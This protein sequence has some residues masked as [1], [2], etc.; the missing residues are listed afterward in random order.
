MPSAEAPHMGR[1]EAQGRRGKWRSKRDMCSGVPA[2]RRRGLILERD[3]RAIP[4]LKRTLRDATHCQPWEQLRPRRQA[5]FATPVKGTLTAATP[6]LAGRK[7]FWGPLLAPH[8]PSLPGPSNLHLTNHQV[9]LTHIV[10]TH[11]L[12][13]LKSCIFFLFVVCLSAQ[14]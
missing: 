13:G 8:H 5:G 10:L 7:R 1:T 2:R 4:T 9:T 12:R 14:E 3:L 11:F 6:A